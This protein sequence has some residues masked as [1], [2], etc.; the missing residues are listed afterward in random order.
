VT[1]A[2]LCW[3][4]STAVDCLSHVYKHCSRCIRRHRG[5]PTSSSS[6]S[7]DLAASS[8][9]LRARSAFSAAAAA[10]R[11]TPKLVSPVN[12]AHPHVVVVSAEPP[13][14]SHFL[15]AT[16]PCCEQSP[17]G[18]HCCCE[19]P[20]TRDV[21]SYHV[22]RSTAT[23][24]GMLTSWCECGEHQPLMPLLC[25]S[26]G[27]DRGG[28]GGGGLRCSSPC[29]SLTYCHPFLSNAD[30]LPPSYSAVCAGRHSRLIRGG[31]TRYSG[32]RF[33]L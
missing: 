20:P 16:A 2:A 32:N 23:S 7:F 30:C 19:M 33:A 12:G 14:Y 24:D 10:T 28:G 31:S 21:G 26:G 3:L 25:S 4:A 29:N 17:C 1:L 13:S 22:M 9:I 27:D 11:G 5:Q 6:S 15:L 18:S 8:R